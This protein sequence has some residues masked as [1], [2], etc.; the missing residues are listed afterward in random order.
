MLKAEKIYVTG[1]QPALRGMRNPK[2]S[3]NRSDTVYVSH[4]TTPNEK[5]TIN[6][7]G[8]IKIKSIVENNSDTDES[9]A[10]NHSICI[11]K[12]DDMTGETKS[13]EVESLDVSKD[14]EHIIREIK[15]HDNNAA[16]LMIEMDKIPIIGEKDLT[17]MKQLCNG[18]PVHGKFARMINV[19]IEISLLLLISG[20][21]PILID[22]AKNA[23]HVLQ[24]ILLLNILLQ[25]III[26]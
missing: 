1:F 24:C 4:I 23:I 11:T 6:T 12:T 15:D 16:T 20:K 21:K 5:I 19:Y 9:F 13:Y 25:S 22:L 14:G 26:L 7:K 18:G 17:L 8:Q 3:W 10:E 2:D